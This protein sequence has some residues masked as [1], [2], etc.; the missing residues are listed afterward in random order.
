VRFAPECRF[1]SSQIFEDSTLPAPVVLF[2]VQKGGAKG[3][4]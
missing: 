4:E 2:K 3:H 1:R